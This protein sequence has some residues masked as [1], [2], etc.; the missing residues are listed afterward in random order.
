MD[1]RCDSSIVNSVLQLSIDRI[2]NGIENMDIKPSLV[3]TGVH[4]PGTGFYLIMIL[5]CLWSVVILLHL[6]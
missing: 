4:H 1:R 5:D 6:Y 3:L 2:L